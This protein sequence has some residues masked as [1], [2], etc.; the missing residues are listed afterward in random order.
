MALVG[1][2]GMLYL[3]MMRVPLN[4]PL[5][6]CL[7]AITG[8]GCFG[9]HPRNIVPVMVGAVIAGSFMD[10][11]DLTS[12]GVLLA[13]LL[14]TGLAPI[15]GQFGGIWGI[16]AGF[17]HM[18]IVQNTSYLYGGLNLYNNGFAAGITCVIMI[19]LIEALKSEPED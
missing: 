19:P 18:S 17:L 13:T 2:I 5:V 12:P 3:S 7:L 14:C 6:C 11:L 4:G 1:A 8:F 9:K 15:A 10:G 16:A